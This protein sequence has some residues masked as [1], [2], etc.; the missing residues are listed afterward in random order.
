ME[1]RI[2]RQSSWKRNEKKDGHSLGSR[3]INSIMNIDWKDS[4]LQALRSASK[5]APQTSVSREANIERERTLL[6]V[7]VATFARMLQ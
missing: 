6:T 2:T 1:N 7:P 5:T 4:N 3:L